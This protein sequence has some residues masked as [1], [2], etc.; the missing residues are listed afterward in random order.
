M[1][2]LL[3]G[4]WQMCNGQVG[5]GICLLLFGWIL[6]LSGG[7]IISIILAYSQCSEYNNLLESLLHIIEST[8]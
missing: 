7:W 8:R 5:L 3:T 1:S 4:L 6:F 2:I